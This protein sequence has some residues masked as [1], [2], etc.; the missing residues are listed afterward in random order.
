MSILPV[1]TAHQERTKRRIKVL[2]VL[3]VPSVIIATILLARCNVQSELTNRTKNKRSV[4]NAQPDRTKLIKDRHIAPSVPKVFPVPEPIRFQSHVIKA[5]TRVWP[6]KTSA[7]RVRRDL[8]RTRQE[9][10]HVSIVRLDTTAMRAAFSQSSV[11]LVHSNHMGRQSL[12][13]TV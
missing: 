8:I 7:F 9:A 6:G 4:L 13:K 2:H 3:T 1:V 11:L 10:L 5:P 12:P